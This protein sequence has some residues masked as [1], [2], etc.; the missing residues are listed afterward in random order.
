MTEHQEEISKLYVDQ[1]GGQDRFT[2]A[3]QQQ[4]YRDMRKEYADSALDGAHFAEFRATEEK[5]KADR[6]YLE[7]RYCFSTGACG[8]YPTPPGIAPSSSPAPK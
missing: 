6:A 5:F 7:D 3:S 4:F 8:G 1:V 2:E